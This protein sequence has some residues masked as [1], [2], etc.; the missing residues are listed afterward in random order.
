MT[1]PLRI[2]IVD[3]EAPARNRLRDVLTDCAVQLPLTIVGEAENGVQALQLLAQTQVDVVLLDI[4]MPG[5]DGMALAQHLAQREHPV[6][7]IFTTAYDAHALQAFELNARDYLLKPVRAER[8]L[9]ALRKVIATTPT[10][11]PPKRQYLSAT[12]RGRV[13]LV[14]IDEV[15]CL[16]AEQ[17][18]V[19]ARTAKHTYLIEDSLTSLEQSFPDYFVRIHRNTLIAKSAIAG[20]VLKDQGDG[21]HSGWFVLLKDSDEALPVSRRQYSVVKQ[22]K[23]GEA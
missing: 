14:P 7:V 6:A 2:L 22:F 4:H 17:K 12:E 11:T 13:L 8:L 19:A 3:D 9:A 16:R 5:M 20:F 23:Q 10:K 21:E 15:I 1:Q 18:Y